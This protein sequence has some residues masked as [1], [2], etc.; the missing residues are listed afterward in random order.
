M[1]WLK[2]KVSD[3]LK[4]FGNPLV[5]IYRDFE[6]KTV[7]I[8]FYGGRC[9]TFSYEGKIITDFIAQGEIYDNANFINRYLKLQGISPSMY[10]PKT[11][12]TNNHRFY[13]EIF[14]RKAI[15]KYIESL[16]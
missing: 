12:K 7:T 6:N 14:K 8:D 3:H 5:K 4:F 15:N 1:G 2:K 11:L 16:R 10:H 9:A 13:S